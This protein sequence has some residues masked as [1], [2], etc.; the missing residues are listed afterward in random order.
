MNK[1]TL[2]PTPT[3]HSTLAPWIEK[4]IAG[5]QACGYKY[6]AESESLRRLDRFLREHGLETP[7][8]PRALV[9]HWIA[10]DPNES[11]RTQRA[12]I[13][14]VRRLAI[15]LLHHGCPAYVPEARLTAKEPSPF[16][17]HIFSREEIRKFLEAADAIPVDPRFPLRHRVLP[18]IFRVL[19][20][21]GPRIGEVVALRVGEV[22][23]LTGILVVREAK[24]RKDRLVPLTPSLGQYLRRYADSLG[25]RPS[26]VPFF[27]APDGGPYHRSTIYHA[28]RQILWRCRISHGGRG[29]GPRLHD[30]RHTFAVHR[31]A[32]WYREGAD[33]NALLPVLAT[34]LGHQSV[35]ET[36][37]YLRLTAELFPDLSARSEAAFGHIIPRR[38]AQ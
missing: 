8:L 6:F 4:F 20:G 14:L 23:L 1:R 33:L 9:E 18:A 37:L 26:E 13:G 12:R 5:K 25:V 17:P 2:T 22:D 36:Q 28:F 16:V 30:L 19:Y 3:F 31:L 27:P 35:I 24:N 32:Q 21:C 7:A 10:K 29:H 11:P 38:P 15:F 34:Y